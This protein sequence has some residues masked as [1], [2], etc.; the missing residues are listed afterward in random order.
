MGFNLL[1]K[2][3]KV[4]PWLYYYF[5]DSLGIIVWQDMVSGFET[6]KRSIQHVHWNAA[7]D[8]ERSSE[9]AAQWEHELKTMIDQLKFSLYRYLGCL[10]RRMG[11]IRY[12]ASSGL[13]NEIRYHSLDRWC[14]WMGRSRLRA[15]ERYTSIPGTWN[16]THEQNPGG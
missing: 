13:G 11:A 15:Y 16:S 1:R 12:R 3:I 8:W 2:H 4:E 14:E 6:D 5:A 7:R 9:S 10:Q